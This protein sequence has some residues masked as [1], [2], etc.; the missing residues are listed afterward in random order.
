[1]QKS[2]TKHSQSKSDPTIHKKII[3]HGQVGFI[4]DMKGWFNI[5]ESTI[6][7]HHID[8]LNMKNHMTVT[9]DAEKVCHKNQTPM[10]DKIILSELGIQRNFLHLI[11]RSTNSTANTLRVRNSKHSPVRSGTR[12]R[13]SL[14]P[15]FF[16]NVLKVYLMQ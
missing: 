9:T 10:H 7:I 11:K 4:L 15:L 8:R 6:V 3:H 16:S 5:R 12:N 13:Y 1:M 14:S 2:S